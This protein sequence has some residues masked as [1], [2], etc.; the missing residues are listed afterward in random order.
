MGT[1]LKSTNGGCLGA[2]IFENPMSS[3]GQRL[4]GDSR[5]VTTNSGSSFSF[6]DEVIGMTNKSTAVV[7]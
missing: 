5:H 7:Q 3:F 4:R 6:S 1:I 2:R